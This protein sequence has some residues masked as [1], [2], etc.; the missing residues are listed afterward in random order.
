MRIGALTEAEAA[1]RK[2]FTLQLSTADAAGTFIVPGI[3]R[4]VLVVE[5]E[6]VYI[7]I[8][9]FGNAQYVQLT[10]NQDSDVKF[11]GKSRICAQGAAKDAVRQVRTALHQCGE[12]NATGRNILETLLSNCDIFGDDNASA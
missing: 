12:D 6:T 1:C 4:I 11:I 8:R 7:L 9:V 10:S 5:T 2:L 3:K